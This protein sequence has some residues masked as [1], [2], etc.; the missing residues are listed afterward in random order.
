MSA[1]IVSR[2]NIRYLDSMISYFSGAPETVAAYGGKS[3][4][5]TS[6][7]IQLEGDEEIDRMVVL[8]F[9]DTESAQACYDSLEYKPLRDQR[10]AAADAKIILSPGE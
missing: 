2:V 9:P 5:R 7:L 6:D 10:W 8:E 1:Y 3:L 4:A